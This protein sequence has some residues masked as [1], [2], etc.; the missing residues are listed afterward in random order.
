MNERNS[1]AKSCAESYT[2]TDN[3]R[4]TGMAGAASASLIPHGNHLSQKPF[5]NDENHET[6]DRKIS[7]EAGDKLIGPVVVVSTI[8]HRAMKC[9]NH[10]YGRIY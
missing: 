4:T 1:N 2:M 3:V 9:Q 8:L 7:P 5:A 10:W 6:C